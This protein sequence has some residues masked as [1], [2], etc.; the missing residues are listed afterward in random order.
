M[1]DEKEDELWGILRSPARAGKK[2]YRG[3]IIT[4]VSDIQFPVSKVL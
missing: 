2:K 4:L 1:W 3:G